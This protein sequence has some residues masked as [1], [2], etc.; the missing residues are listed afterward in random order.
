MLKLK[1][2]QQNLHD[3]AN[4][5][6]QQMKKYLEAVINNILKKQEDLVTIY[7]QQLKS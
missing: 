5:E 7:N 3:N 1:N 2:Q 6:I 4:F